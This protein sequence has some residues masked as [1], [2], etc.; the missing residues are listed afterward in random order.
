MAKP[1]AVFGFTKSRKHN[2]KEMLGKMLDVDLEIQRADFKKFQSQKS[3][4]CSTVPRL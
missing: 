4:N 1:L 3:E 2:G